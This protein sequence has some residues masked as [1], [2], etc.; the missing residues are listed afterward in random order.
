MEKLLECWILKGIAEEDELRNQNSSIRDWRPMD[1][2]IQFIVKHKAKYPFLMTFSSNGA[3]IF[4]RTVVS[5]IYH[6][7]Q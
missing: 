6:I 2:L 4:Y 5:W 1:F 3:L 7:T